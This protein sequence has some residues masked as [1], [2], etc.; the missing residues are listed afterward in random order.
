MTTDK[1]IL[2]K[3]DL[4][5]IQQLLKK[6]PDTDFFSLTQE[7]GSGIGSVLTMSFDY[8]VEDIRGTF[9]TEINGVEDW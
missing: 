4:S 1:I 7:S 5:K 3:N 2:N 6:F 9:T 8:S